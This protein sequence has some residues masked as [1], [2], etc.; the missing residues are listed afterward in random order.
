MG[1]TL[2]RAPY[3]RRRR[4]TEARRLQR[5]QRG[6]AADLG[7]PAV[8]YT[9]LEPRTGRPRTSRPQTAL[10]LTRLSLAL[11][12]TVFVVGV[13]LDV[14]RFKAACQAVGG[15]VVTGLVPGPEPSS[16]DTVPSRTRHARGWLAKARYAR[17]VGRWWSSTSARSP[18][19]PLGVATTKLAPTSSTSGSN[20][21]SDPN[22][23]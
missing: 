3:R 5:H 8:D 21:D 17:R 20:I 18:I 19:M 9:G 14:L 15:R 13:P 4:W 10:L 22:S 7:H 2:L 16:D 11:Y 1:A 12:R 6:T 23:L